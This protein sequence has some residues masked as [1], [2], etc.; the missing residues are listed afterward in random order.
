MSHYSMSRDMLGDL[1]LVSCSMTSP[2]PG[3]CLDNTRLFSDCWYIY[4]Q[5]R[6]G[7]IQPAVAKQRTSDS[8]QTVPSTLCKAVSQ[9]KITATAASEWLHLGAVL[10]DYLSATKCLYSKV[11]TNKL[12]ACLSPVPIQIFPLKWPPPCQSSRP[13]T[14]TTSLRTPMRSSSYRMQCRSSSS[15]QS[16]QGL[17]VQ[18]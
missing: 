17:W 1:W 3:S 6:R 5:L 16:H 15:W 13:M 12:S 7:V 18:Y 11:I 4:C 14:S 8:C 10:P 2:W 9:S